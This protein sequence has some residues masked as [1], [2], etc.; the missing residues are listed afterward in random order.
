MLG[1]GLCYKDWRARVAGL[2]DPLQKL[3]LF[4]HLGNYK[5][6][7][8]CLSLL[9]RASERLRVHK[10]VDE[11]AQAHNYNH[12]RLC[13]RS[14]SKQMQVEEGRRSVRLQRL[15][16]LTRSARLKASLAHLNSQPTPHE[17]NINHKP[18][19]LSS[20]GGAE[21]LINYTETSSESLQRT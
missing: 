21:M 1:G 3:P 7:P 18:R 5:E 20:L 4:P 2:N 11:A 15:S 14:P 10:C 9:R 12:R 19:R 16:Q 8:A 17:S 13:V 6:V